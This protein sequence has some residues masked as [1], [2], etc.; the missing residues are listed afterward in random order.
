MP[1]PE[2]VQESCFVVNNVHEKWIKSL[3][4]TSLDQSKSVKK[5]KNLAIFCSQKVHKACSTNDIFPIRFSLLWP[6][7]FYI[8]LQKKKTGDEAALK[9]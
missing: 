8:Q 7:N 2:C 6:E 4:G 9:I 3:A 1:G 5:L